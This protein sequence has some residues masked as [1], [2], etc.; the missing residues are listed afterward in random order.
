LPYQM[1]YLY[2]FLYLFLIIISIV[3]GLLSIIQTPSYNLPF[4]C[5]PIPDTI[6]I[7]YFNSAAITGSNYTDYYTTQCRLSLFTLININSNNNNNNIIDFLKP[8]FLT[9]GDPHSKSRGSA[10]HVI[11]RFCNNHMLIG[12]TI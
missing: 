11:L 4:P 3:N 2:C 9:Y 10:N 8:G 12:L 7:S 5:S 6:T 1:S